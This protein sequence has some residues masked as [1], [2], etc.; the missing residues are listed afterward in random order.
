M[1]RKAP[2]VQHPSSGETPITKC[3]HSTLNIQHPTSE[4]GRNGKGQLFNFGFGGPGCVRE[5]HTTVR[6]THITACKRGLLGCGNERPQTPDGLWPAGFEG[7]SYWVCW[8]QFYRVPVAF[9]S[10]NKSKTCL[11]SCILK[12]PKI[13]AGSVTV[14]AGW[15]RRAWCCWPRWHWWRPAARMC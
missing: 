5:W 4:H 2:S 6:G 3:E 14:P 8:D 10:I 1:A 9:D 11:S 15:Q 12:L 13:I 7:A